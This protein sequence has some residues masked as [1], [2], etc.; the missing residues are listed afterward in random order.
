M[1]IVTSQ[2]KPRSM[3]ELLETVPPKSSVP[4]LRVNARAHTQRYTSQAHTSHTF[5]LT[6]H[7]YILHTHMCTHTEVF[8]VLYF[9]QLG[10]HTYYSET[11]F[12]IMYHRNIHL[13]ISFS[14]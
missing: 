14:C 2:T 3:R 8:F 11:I 4:P 10:N 6:H 9:A 12:H 5:I 7:A 1:L 13:C